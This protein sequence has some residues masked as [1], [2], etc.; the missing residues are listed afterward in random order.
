MHCIFFLALQRGTKPYFGHWWFPCAV[1]CPASPDINDQGTAWKFSCPFSPYSV[2]PRQGT[3]C[4]TNVCA[5]R[6]DMHL[7]RRVPEQ[8]ADWQ[9]PS[10]ALLRQLCSQWIPESCYTFVYCRCSNAEFVCNWR[11]SRALDRSAEESDHYYPFLHHFYII[12][13]CLDSNN[14]SVTTYLYNI[15]TSLLCIKM[16]VITSLLHVITVIMGHFHLLLQ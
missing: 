3:C 16:H 6:I 12:I 9:P 2:S 10:A 14:G 4:K 5:G 11:C 8:G 7:R 15:I 13:T 1:A